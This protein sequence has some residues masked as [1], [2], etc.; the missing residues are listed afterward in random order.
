MVAA[1]GLGWI[2]L[3][4]AIVVVIGLLYFVFGRGRV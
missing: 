3:V 4:L 1:F 2:G